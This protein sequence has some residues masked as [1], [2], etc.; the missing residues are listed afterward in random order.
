MFLLFFVFVWSDDRRQD[1]SDIRRALL[2]IGPLCLLKV[3]ISGEV[4]NNAQRFKPVNSVHV[5]LLPRCNFAPEPIRPYLEQSC[6]CVCATGLM[7]ASL[8]ALR[9]TS[10][11]AWRSFTDQPACEPP[12]RCELIC[13]KP[14]WFQGRVDS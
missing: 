12:L 3:I 7:I 10:Y 6:V 8:F 1:M 13:G 9:N 14:D 4:L 11:P 2:G 5:D